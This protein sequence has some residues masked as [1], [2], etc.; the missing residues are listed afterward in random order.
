[1]L[2]GVE[3]INHLGGLIILPRVC[4]AVFTVSIKNHSLNTEGKA[5][6]GRLGNSFM[7]KSGQK[8]SFLLLVTE[9]TNVHCRNFFK[10]NK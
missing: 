7:A 9:V 10:M 4:K 8:P 3:E 6:A 1:M 2:G 5:E